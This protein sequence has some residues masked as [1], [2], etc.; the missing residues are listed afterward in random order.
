[1][2]IN[3]IFSH[4]DRL[5]ENKK[6]EEVEPYPD[7]GKIDAALRAVNKSISEPEETLK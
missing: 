6:A 4:V 3:K 5:F 2:E 1:M 7:K